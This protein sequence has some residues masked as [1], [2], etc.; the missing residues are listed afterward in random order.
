MD[1]KKGTII[2]TTKRTKQDGSGDYYSVKVKGSDGAQVDY[3]CFDSKMGDKKAGDTVEFTA[4]QKGDVWFLNFPKEGRAGGYGG[5][6]SY[7]AGV[8]DDT[9]ARIN[10]LLQ[11]HT[12]PMS[13][14]KDLTGDLI[15][16]GIIITPEAARLVLLELYH[17]MRGQILADTM[18]MA[19]LTG[20]PGGVP[21]EGKPPTT[22]KTHE[23]F[24]KALSFFVEKLVDGDFVLPDDFAPKLLQRLSATKTPE[25]LVGGC[26]KIEDMT[27]AEAKT[28]F[29]RFQMFLTRECPADRTSCQY[30]KVGGS[31][32]WIATCPYT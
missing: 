17:E 28:A 18:L 24:K 30:F 15:E 13:Y 2:S 1:L 3:L 29:N 8:K 26:K 32:S 25:G 23:E 16:K 14:A 27:E 10:G 6:A 22:S 7:G 5:R 11:S 4:V 9:Y 21:T 20:K 31:C 19:L 12:M